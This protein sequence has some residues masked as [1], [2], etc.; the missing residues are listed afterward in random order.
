[1]NLGNFSIR[2]RPSRMFINEGNLYI[3]GNTS[4]DVFSNKFVL[5]K[6]IIQG[7]E[8]IRFS[9]DI[10]LGSKFYPSNIFIHDSTVFHIE[11]IMDPNTKVESL[12]IEK[13]NI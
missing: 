12:I 3:F 11:S 6:V 7:S 10:E 4:L 5:E 1:M 13:V 2:S 8:Y 9:N